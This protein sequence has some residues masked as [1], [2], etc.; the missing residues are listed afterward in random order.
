MDRSPDVPSQVQS[1]YSIKL[2]CTSSGAVTTSNNLFYN[3]EG[4]DWIDIFNKTVTV[5]FLD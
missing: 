4:Y 2:E 1:S 3:M 5:S